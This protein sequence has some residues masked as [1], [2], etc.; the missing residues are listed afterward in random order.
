M[1]IPQDVYHSEG[2]HDNPAYKRFVKDGGI[3]VPFH[4]DRTL[5]IEET[6]RIIT[7]N[8]YLVK[9]HDR[10][11]TVPFHTLVSLGQ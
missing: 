8:K 10:M 3:I 11:K 7:D 2:C 5:F 4:T 1:I 9:D 6:K